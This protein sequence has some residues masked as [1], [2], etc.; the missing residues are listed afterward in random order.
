MKKRLMVTGGSG[1]VAGSVIQQ[2]GDEWEVHVLS[3]KDALTQRQN[4]FWHKLDLL[5][6]QQLRHVFVEAGPD[7]IV[8]TA[9]IADI[10]FC[11]SH[12]ELAVQV[13]IDLTRRVADLCRAAGV[14]MVHLSTD[15]VFDGEKGSYLETDPPGPVN[16]YAETKVVA[17]TIVSGMPGDRVIARLALVMGLPM[18]GAGNSFLPRFVAMLEQGAEIGMSTE[19]IR[20]PIDVVTLGRALLELAGNDVQGYI[21]L[22]GNDALTRFEMAQRIAAR[23]GYP[24]SLI[25]AKDSG[26][27]PGRAP[28]P[29]DVSL[30]NARARSLLRTPTCGLDEGLEL[31]LAA[32]RGE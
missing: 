29:R 20:T 16:Y 5:D 23:L 18:L 24:K 3:G 14:R 10:D 9:A 4:L 31:V 27:T 32:R 19:E 30:N 17:E 25:V 21:H 6:D 2:A 26:S 28:R 8:H 15:T 22:A 13:N 12:K 11:E 7:V 1:F